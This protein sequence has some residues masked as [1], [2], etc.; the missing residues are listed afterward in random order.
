MLNSLHHPER[1]LAGHSEAAQRLRL[2]L[3]RV[4]PHYRTAVLVGEPG[5]LKRSVAH[6]LQARSPLREHDLHAHDA[7]TLPGDILDVAGPATLYVAGIGKLGPNQQDCILARIRQGG[8]AGRPELR[9]ICSS[10]VAPRG[11]V[12]AGKL[13]A[14]LYSCISAVEIRVP[15]LRERLEDLPALLEGVEIH[16]VALGTLGEHHWPGNLRELHSVVSACMA[17]AGTGTIGP[18]HLP[19]FAATQAEEGDLK[20][21]AVL[22][23]HVSAV[24]ESCAGN[25][26]RAAEMLGISRSTLYRMLETNQA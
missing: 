15:P 22:R 26:L 2:Q 13:N 24:L 5:C 9:L 7:S 6:A 10:D 3:D 21:E 17:R 19:A 8:R 1:V 25:K 20:L 4:A 11:L 12:A 14:E 18:E 16:P 23:R